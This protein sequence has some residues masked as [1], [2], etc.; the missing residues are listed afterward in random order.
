M[1]KNAHRIAGRTASRSGDSNHVRPLDAIT[2]RSGA[3][4]ANYRFERQADPSPAEIAAATA[5]IRRGWSERQHRTRAGLPET[6]VVEI[7]RASAR[8]RVAEPRE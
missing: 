8:G 1:T 5:E 3:S 4:Q 6:D 2:G 7:R